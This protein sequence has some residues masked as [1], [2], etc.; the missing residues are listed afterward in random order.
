MVQRDQFMLYIHAGSHHFCGTD[1]HSDFSFTHLCKQLL[2]CFGAFVILNEANLF[3]RNAA[4]HELILDFLI[5]AESVIAL[6]LFACRRGQIGENQLCFIRALL[7]DLKDF[8]GASINFTAAEVL[9]I[10]NA[11]IERDRLAVTDN[12][13][14]I[15]F[16]GFYS[17]QANQ[18]CAFSQLLDHCLLFL[19]RLN[20]N[21]ISLDFGNRQLERFGCLN[22]GDLLKHRHQLR[23]I[24]EFGKPRFGA[25][26]L[27]FGSDLQRRDRFAERRRPTVEVHQ[28]HCFQRVRLQITLHG[29]HFRHGIC[30]R[31]TRSKH[32]TSARIELVEVVDLTV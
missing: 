27:A 16:V 12:F 21:N 1:Q 24:I 18:L 31:C 19:C 32:N 20:L 5:G 8:F 25:V 17:P 29:E 2:L 9:G 4:Q 15:I 23:Y 26:A 14:D 30:N 13:Q 28:A 3:F 7:P 10:Q 6:C 22:V 11:R